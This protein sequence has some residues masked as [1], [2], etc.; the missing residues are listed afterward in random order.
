MPNGHAVVVVL[1]DIGHSPRMC[2]HAHSLAQQ[3]VQVELVGYAGSQ[4]HARIAD[5]PLIRPVYM[6]APPRFMSHARLPRLLQLLCKFAWTFVF[7]AWT[8]LFQTSLR[9]DLIL[10]QNPPGV[11]AMLVCWLV[12][13]CAHTISNL[14]VC[15]HVGIRS[16]AT[17][18]M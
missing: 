3:Q 5:D 1:G 2:Y 13:A 16:S 17:S 10:M 8:L 6:P 4:P 14:F 9:V 11:P 18:T 7:L 15:M 12:S